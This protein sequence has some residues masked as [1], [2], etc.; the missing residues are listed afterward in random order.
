M[1]FA[2]DQAAFEDQSKVAIRLF[3]QQVS[4]GFWSGL[5]GVT[6]D[7]HPIFHCEI[8]ADVAFPAVEIFAVE[9]ENWSFAGGQLGYSLNTPVGC[10][11]VVGLQRIK[12][13]NK[14][15]DGEKHRSNKHGM[16]PVRGRS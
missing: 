6:S 13:Q 2:G 7:D 3:R 10:F 5:V 1:H 16:S 14:H 12:M 11:L 4:A 9:Q 8:F 15:S